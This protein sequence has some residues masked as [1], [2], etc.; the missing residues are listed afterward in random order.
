MDLNTVQLTRQIYSG[1][2]QWTNGA[3]EVSWTFAGTTLSEMLT[4]VAL[5]TSHHFYPSLSPVMHKWMRMQMLAGPPSNL[6][7]RTRGDL[8]GGRTQPGWRTYMMT[9][10][11]W[12]LAYMRLEIWQKI[13]LSA[14]WCL[15][16]ALCTRSGACYYWIEDLP[17]VDTLNIM[18]RPTTQPQPAFGHYDAVSAFQNYDFCEARLPILCS[19]CLEL[20]S[21]NC[22]E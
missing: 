22:S 9:C 20:T 6:L 16:T 1:L 10:L 11:N 3:Y 12:I 18:D 2:M 19:G 15:C 14:D 7:Q 4:S 5:P 17:T 21:K 13:G 8:R